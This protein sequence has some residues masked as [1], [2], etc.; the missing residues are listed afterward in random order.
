MRVAPDSINLKMSDREVPD[1]MLQESINLQW[2]DGSIKPIPYRGVSDIDTTGYFD[3]LTHKVADENIINVLGFSDVDGRLYHF[4]TLTDGSY[5]STTPSLV[6]DG[7]VW[8]ADLSFTILSGL[9]YF[10]SASQKIYY[11]V[12]YD[13]TAGDYLSVDMYSW[14]HGSDVYLRE[15]GAMYYTAS[16]SICYACGMYLMRYTFVLDTGE[17]VLHSAIYPMYVCDIR[18]S[19][20]VDPAVIYAHSRIKFKLGGVSDTGNITHVNIYTTIPKYDLE[21]SLNPQGS[22]TL[23]QFKKGV[24]MDYISANVGS[25]YYRIASYDIDKV[26]SDGSVDGVDV[27]LYSGI[28]PDDSSGV[29]SVDMATIASGDVMP[30]DNFTHSE[31]YGNIGSYNGRLHVSNVHTELASSTVVSNFH[32][33]GASKYAS[34]S[35]KHEVETEDGIVRGGKSDGGIADASG[36]II[37]LLSYPDYRGK[38]IR[39]ETQNLNSAKTHN[40]IGVASSN[41]AVVL[42]SVFYSGSNTEDT[43][44][45][46]FDLDSIGGDDT[47]LSTGDNSYNSGNRLQFSAAGEFRVFAVENSYRI[48]EG[49]IVF[50]GSNKV[51]PENADVVAPLLVG[52]TDGIYSVNLD[53]TGVSFVNSI[54]KTVNLPAISSETL[55]IESALLFVSDKGLI[56]INNGNVDNLTN[57]SFPEQSY[58]YPSPNSTLPNYDECLKYPNGSAYIQPSLYGVSDIV[59]YMKGAI[60]AYDGRRNNVWCCNPSYNNSMIYNLPLRKWSASTIVYNSKVELYSVIDG[61]YS[62]YLVKGFYTEGGLSQSPPSLLILSSESSTD[63]VTYHMLTRPIKLDS[64]DVYKKINRVIARCQLYMEVGGVFSLG[65]WGKQDINRYAQAIPLVCISDDTSYKNNRRQDIPVGSRKG[66]YKA[67][68]VLQSGVASPDSSIDGFDFDVSVVDGGKLR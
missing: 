6:S 60:M 38:R 42:P 40:L 54:T 39:V 29:I 11:R 18:S 43:Y 32:D 27:I 65:V 22:D 53:P 59:D 15:L 13:E 33:F 57:S 35:S 61:C 62:R 3:I 56:V 46:R 48:G 45:A 4:G 51:N 24:Y 67:L 55:E 52:T 25:N 49:K 23:D 26:I 47:A 50:V 28:T 5:S 66:K 8:S 64:A 9:I 19:S 34:V 10:M 20:S 1:G 37:G 7:F 68:V 17:E 41:I 12:Q 58:S 31:I 30:V 2:R 63:D 21:F 16:S 36:E 14:K 44:F